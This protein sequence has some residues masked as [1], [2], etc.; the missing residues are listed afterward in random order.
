ML[1][2]GGTAARADMGAP[3]TRVTASRDGLFLSASTARPFRIAPREFF[4]EST[5]P[6]PFEESGA[7]FV[8][9]KRC[10]SGSKAMADSRP[11]ERIRAV[12]FPSRMEREVRSGAV[13]ARRLALKASRGENFKVSHFSPSAAER[14]CCGS[15]LRA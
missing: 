7:E 10:W 2:A 13:V 4:S 1:R 8:F 15:P 5:S 12:L 14:S 9:T 11:G 3:G 6:P